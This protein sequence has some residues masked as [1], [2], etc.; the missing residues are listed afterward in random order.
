VCDLPQN[1]SLHVIAFISSEPVSSL[2]VGSTH[3]YAE[4]PQQA[5]S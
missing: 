4:Q 1:E 5:T 3:D 2:R